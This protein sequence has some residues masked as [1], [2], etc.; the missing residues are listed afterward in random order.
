[1]DTRQAYFNKLP[2]QD[3]AHREAHKK[4]EICHILLPYNVSETLYQQLQRVAAVFHRPTESIVLDSLRHTL[5]SLFEEIPAEY[6]DVSP[7]LCGGTPG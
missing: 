5:P 4:S 1:M 3:A 7:K 6:Q 2:T